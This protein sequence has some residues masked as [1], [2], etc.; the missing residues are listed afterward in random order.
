VSG[1]NAIVDWILLEVRDTATK[2]I[3]ATR[4]ALVQRDGEI[5]DTN[6]VSG[7]VFS[8]VA[9]GYYYVSVKHRNHLGV[10]LNNATLLTLSGSPIDF[11]QQSLWVK[12]SSPAIVNIPARN[13]GL[14]QVLWAGDARFNKNTKYNGF[15]NDKEVILTAVG[16]GT[17]NNV[18]LP[19]YRV[20]DVNMD[21]VVK[22]NNA[23][24]DRNVI[25]NTVGVLTPNAIYNQHT[26]D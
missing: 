23:N 3:V 13:Y 21:G 12:P 24:N 2:A 9:P 17:P 7:V 1:T 18:T 11:T 20:E 22:Y 16:I 25:L 19:D 10:M 14:T 26:P 8:T 5:V 15:Q 4:R 6:G